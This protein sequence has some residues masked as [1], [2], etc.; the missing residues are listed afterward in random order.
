MIDSGPVGSSDVSDA[1]DEL[2]VEAVR[3]GL[4]RPMWPECAPLAG[5]VRAVRLDDGADTPL[6][7]LLEVLAGA[8]DQLVLVDL[9]RRLDVQCWGAGL[10]A[11]ARSFRAPG[12]LIHGAPPDPEGLRE[13]RLPTY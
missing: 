8:G 1:C 9:G 4:L 3:T 5:R 12:A 6:P 13:P 10:G 2:G 7:E 11:A